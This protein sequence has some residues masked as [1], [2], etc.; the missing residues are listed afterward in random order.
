M[1]LNMKDK[2]LTKKLLPFFVLLL[3]YQGVFAQTKIDEYWNENSDRESAR[4]DNLLM[5]LQQDPESKGLI[6]I[7]SGE[8]KEQL[9]NI[10]GQIEG[11]KEWIK[12]RKI[13]PQ[14][15]S[16]IVTQGKDWLFKELWI[17]K[18]GEEF[19]EFKPLDF[20]L[21]KVNEKYL[22]AK[23][24][25]FC[26][27]TVPILDASN[28]DESLFGEILSKNNRLKGMIAVSKDYLKYAIDFRK[29]LMKKFN[30]DVSQISI[31]I[32]SDDIVHFYI[33]PK[34][35]KNKRK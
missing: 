30:L 29:R 4:I 21:S 16:F 14:R 11:I 34:M 12:R 23:K 1:I 24:C 5:S 8:K 9:G 27:P 6:V 7:Y 35:I 13:D 32:T 3:A 33:A 19:P 20:D 22:Y 17:A 15:I 25:L 28:V 26:E 18:K 10:L 2:N 31:R